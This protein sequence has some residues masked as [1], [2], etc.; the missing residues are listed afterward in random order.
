RVLGGKIYTVAN[1]DDVPGVLKALPRRPGWKMLLASLDRAGC[2]EGRRD[3]LSAAIDA[4]LARLDGSRIDR[5]L[6]RAIA[7]GRLDNARETTTIVRAR[8][9]VREGSE[10]IYGIRCDAQVAAY[11]IGPP[12]RTGHVDLVGILQFEGLRRLRAGPPFPLARLPK[13]WHPDWKDLRHARPL[14][15]AVSSGWLVPDL[16]TPDI[17]QRNLGLSEDATGPTIDFRGA[18]RVPNDPVRAVFASLIA[19]GGTVGHRDDRVD[20]HVGISIPTV[21]CAFEVWLHESIALLS[22]PAPTL[23]GAIDTFMQPSSTS[24]QIHLPLEAEVARI[25]SPSLPAAFRPSARPHATIVRRAM[26]V[27][28]GNPG[29]YRGFRLIVPD[30][31]IGSRVSLRWRM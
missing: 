2:P 20:L 4:V 1:S 30:P 17:W 28:G 13:S 5:P 14:G 8:R 27:I 21:R 6:L 11:V 18:A 26:S 16:S 15:A 31:P 3:E 23:V 10:Q 25:D 22:E 12:D 9:A 7:E 19:E 29:E 24:D